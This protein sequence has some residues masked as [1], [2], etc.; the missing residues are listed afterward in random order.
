MEVREGK[1]EQVWESEEVR[2]TDQVREIRKVRE[3]HQPKRG[4]ACEGDTT[5]MGVRKSEEGQA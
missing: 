1:E 5:G 3:I 2:E 4:M